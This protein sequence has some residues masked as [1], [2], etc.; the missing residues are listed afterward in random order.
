MIVLFAALGRRTHDA[1]SPVGGTLIVAA[2]FMIGYLV[3]A[4]LT[5]LWRAPTSV[6]RVALT[7]APG[8]ALG[9]LLRRVVFDRGTA[10]AFVIVAFVTTAVLLIGSRLVA[11]AISRR[12]G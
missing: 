7:W 6:V 12:S 5:G 11:R 10:T 3:S 8:I 4:L 2:P 1:G 9:M